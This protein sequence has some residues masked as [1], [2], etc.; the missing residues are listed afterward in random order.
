[1][2][3]CGMNN[4]GD[5]TPS[6][7]LAKHPPACTSEEQADDDVLGKYAPNERYDHREKLVERPKADELGIIQSLWN[8]ILL[9]DN[10]TLKEPNPD[11]LVE[12]LMSRPGR[13]RDPRRL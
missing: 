10:T 7:K 8:D 1:M 9:H 3:I 6:F 12:S 11:A 4:P 13:G 5:G 2:P